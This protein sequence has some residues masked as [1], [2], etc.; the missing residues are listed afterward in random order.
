MLAKRILTA[1]LGIPILLGALY[2]GGSVWR[3]LV[4]LII[5]IGLVEFARIS[6]PGLYIDY[7]VVAGLSF[8]VLTYSGLDGTKLLLWL[9]FQFLYYLIRATFSGMHLFSSA[10]NLLALFYVVVLYSFLVLV[11]EEFGIVWTVFG[12][13]VTWLTDTGAYFGGMRYGKRRLAPSISPKKSVEGA[14]FGLLT[15]ALTGFAF[16][17]LT[18]GSPVRTVSFAIVLSISAQVGDL[19]ESAMKRERSVKDSGSL[20]PGHGG[21]LDRFDSLALVF[22]VLF[23][24]LSAFS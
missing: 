22:P 5:L 4:F 6:G 12:L 11:R 20:L 3:T 17:L 14:V 24:L 10:F 7:L 9:V 16:A 23:A 19:V 15:A 13:S 2:L 21:I 1:V 8:L 18:N